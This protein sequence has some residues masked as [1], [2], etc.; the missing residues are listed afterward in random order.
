MRKVWVWIILTV[1][2][3]LFTIPSIL[4]HRWTN[5]AWGIGVVLLNAAIAWDQW[6]RAKPPK[7]V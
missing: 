7:V 6:R 3:A 2:M 5:A 4:L 1:A